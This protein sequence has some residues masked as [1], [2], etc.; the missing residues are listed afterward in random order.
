MARGLVIEMKVGDRLAIDGGR[1]AI[2]LEQKH[3][4]RARI[5]VEADRSVKIG[6]LQPGPEPAKAP[7]P[8]GVG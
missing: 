1:V 4:Q 2:V 6:E 7:D 8:L 3:G 5:R